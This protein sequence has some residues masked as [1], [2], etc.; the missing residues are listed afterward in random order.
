MF[1]EIGKKLIISLNLNPIINIQTLIINFNNEDKH[2]NI[3]LKNQIKKKKNKSKRNTKNKKS[4][5]NI[6]QLETMVGKKEVN[7]K[8][9]IN[10]LSQTDFDLQDMDYE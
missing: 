4:L 7:N 10:D 9:V 8:P 2:I 3:N 5:K 6:N 1:S